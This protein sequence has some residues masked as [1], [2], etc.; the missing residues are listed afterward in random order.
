MTASKTKEK[1]NQFLPAS[2]LLSSLNPWIK[3]RRG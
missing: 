1:K 3:A 2:F